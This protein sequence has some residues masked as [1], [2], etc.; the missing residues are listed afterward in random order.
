MYAHS[1]DVSTS[2]VVDEA[3]DINVPLRSISTEGKSGVLPAEFSLVNIN[4]SNVIIETV[5]KAED[6]D[7]VIVRMYETWNSRTDCEVSFGLDVKD[8]YECNLMEEKDE[9]LTLSGGKLN[10]TFKP[11]EIKTLKVYM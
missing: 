2:G 8:A 4:K 6:S 5:K 10:L 3:Y 1:G 9:K 11:F 7:A